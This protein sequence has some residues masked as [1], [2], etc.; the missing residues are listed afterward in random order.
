MSKPKRGATPKKDKAPSPKKDTKKKAAAPVAAND[1]H[2]SSERDIERVIVDKEVP[3]A[4][5]IEDANRQAHAL[6][7]V[8]SDI[9]VIDDEIAEFMSGKRKKRRE[10][11]KEQQRLT[12]AV[13]NN[14]TTER[15][16]C[17]EVRIFRTNTVRYETTKE[18]PRGAGV[19]LSERAMKPGEFDQRTI[20]DVANKE[21]VDAEEEAE[22]DEAEEH[23]DEAEEEEEEEPE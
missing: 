13:L 19:L 1:Q 2:L 21:R 11:V 23:D 6:A 18:D 10:L 16:K 17:V 5:S 22:L 4:S 9:K 3:R 7:K 20:E 15:I 12:P 14:T 8:T